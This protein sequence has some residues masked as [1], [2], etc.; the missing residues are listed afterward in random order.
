MNRPE[1]FFSL[2]GLP[3]VLDSDGVDNAHAWN[4]CWFTQ[5]YMAQNLMG[6]HRRAPVD[7]AFNR[8]TW[9][10]LESHTRTD[11]K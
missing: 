5:V 9:N 6:A 4:R 10:R 7:R 3:H 2:T 1:S 8:S 11:S